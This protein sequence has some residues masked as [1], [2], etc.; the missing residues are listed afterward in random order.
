[1][2]FKLAKLLN[3][4]LIG[5]TLIILALVGGYFYIAKNVPSIKFYYMFGAV[6]VGILLL[7]L[8]KWLENSWDKKIITKMAHSGKIALANIKSSKR[9]LN[10]RDSN[11]TNYWL[12]QFEAELITPDEYKIEQTFY[13]KMN[14]ETGVIPNG[15]VYVTYDESKPNQIFIVPNVMISHLPNLIP[16]IAKL[17]KNKHIDIKY[18][19]VYYN[20][21]MVI[22]TFRESLSEQ[23]ANAAKKA[24]EVSANTAKKQVKG[25][26]K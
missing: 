7:W 15:S 21:G 12:Y 16:I 19:D 20:K 9:V 10:M 22:K 8:F 25:K 11:F 14:C 17:E 3:N 23:K 13:E 1:M 2:Q 5:I 24:A 4:A 6:V 26:K 18:L